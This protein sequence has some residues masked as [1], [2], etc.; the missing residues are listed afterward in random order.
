MNHTRLVVAVSLEGGLE[1]G[2]FAAQLA[3]GADESALL[4]FLR[5]VGHLRWVLL[6]EHRCGDEEGHSGDLDTEGS[7]IP[8]EGEM[9]NE[10]CL[11]VA[12]LE[13]QDCDV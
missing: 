1:R 10:E 13:I 5:L 9:V 6:E 4:V 2:N 12:G 7:C 11:G 8:T 3:H